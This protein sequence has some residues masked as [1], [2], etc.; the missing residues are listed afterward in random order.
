MSWK[1][2]FIAFPVFHLLI[3][4]LFIIVTGD[5]E[6]KTTDGYIDYEV[7]ND[8]LFDPK[9]AMVRGSSSRP[10]NLNLFVYILSVFVVKFVMAN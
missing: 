1:S 6:N 8:P 10:I 7:D 3:V 5:I 4:I 9:P 2:T